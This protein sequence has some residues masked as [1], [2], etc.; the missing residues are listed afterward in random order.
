MKTILVA[1]TNKRSLT[2]REIRNTKLYSFNTEADLKE[3]DIIESNSYSTRMLV[4]KILEKAFRYYNTSNGD[5]T[6]N[7]TSI[8][9][10]DIA[11]L[12][13]GKGRN[14]D[15]VYGSLVK[16]IEVW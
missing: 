16:D 6:D 3:G 13:I 14:S 8:L 5:L 2:A 12:V 4:V 9:N 11:I 1:F 7:F 10:R 15:V